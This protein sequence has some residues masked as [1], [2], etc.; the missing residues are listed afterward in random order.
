M[1]KGLTFSRRKSLLDYINEKRAR[2][3]GAPDLRRTQAVML[4]D[5]IRESIELIRKCS[6]GCPTDDPL[7]LDEACSTMNRCLSKVDRKLMVSWFQLA[8]DELLLHGLLRLLATGCGCPKAQLTS[9]ILLCKICTI[10]SKQ[11]EQAYQLSAEK[12]VINLV[13]LLAAPL[14]IL[15]TC[16]NLGRIVCWVSL[17]L[18]GMITVS[19]RYKRILAVH[20]LEDWGH[21]VLLIPQLLLATETALPNLFFCEFPMDDQPRLQRFKQIIQNEDIDLEVFS[22]LFKLLVRCLTGSFFPQDYLPSLSNVCHVRLKCLLHFGLPN[23]LLAVSAYWPC[24]S[25]Q[26]SLSKL[27]ASVSQPCYNGWSDLDETVM[28]ALH[29][30]IDTAFKMV[31]STD[32]CLD[33]MAHAGTLA[34]SCVR[35]IAGL[36]Q[37]RT[38]AYPA[39]TTTCVL[40]LMR[41]VGQCFTHESAG[42]THLCDPHYL[43]RTVRRAA[44]WLSFR[45]DWLLCADEV[46]WTL[47]NV[48]GHLKH[49]ILITVG[50]PEGK[51]LF[52]HRCLQPILIYGC[53]MEALR[54][55]YN[56]CCTPTQTEAGDVKDWCLI[57]ACIERRLMNQELP[58]WRTYW[59]NLDKSH[60][61]CLERLTQLI[62]GVNQTNGLTPS[63]KRV[64]LDYI[65]QRCHYLDTIR[66][67]T[68]VCEPV[69]CTKEHLVNLCTVLIQSK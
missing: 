29:D 23:V 2:E 57:L 60:L 67:E 39:K 5:S 65:G 38:S 16:I 14:A 40:L 21:K 35:L 54:L 28:C 63:D 33:Q 61:L 7:L 66:A 50:E 47:A 58:M 24:N 26:N 27:A 36:M 32:F 41:I 64:L 11:T 25:C 69:L 17:A 4:Q 53:G 68:V 3:L 9:A 19:L 12:G 34:N 20:S 62:L 55:L 46:S 52:L 44:I 10:A 31:T 8:N 51:N 30:L 18:D 6:A 49:S 13:R 45:M 48:V 22:A 43:L 42:N 37:C 59:P 1:S 15:I 56:S